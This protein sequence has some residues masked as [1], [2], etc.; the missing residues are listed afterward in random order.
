MQHLRQLHL[1]GRASLSPPRRALPHLC[2]RILA[3]G[4]RPP[5]ARPPARP[6]RRAGTKFNSRKEDAAGET[7]LGIQV[8]RLYIKCTKCSAEISLKTDPK[9]SDYILE[10][11]ATR[12]YEPWRDAESQVP[13]PEPAPDALT[14]P[15]FSSSPP[16]RRCPGGPRSGG[17]TNNPS[18]RLP[19]PAAPRSWTRRGRSARRR[20]RGTR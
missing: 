4:A 1:Q 18:P 3:C 13:P 15:A 12:N 5:A 11:G 17:R 7:Y 10:A 8:V 19:A 16:S 9:N 20:R 2:T 14:P 6:S